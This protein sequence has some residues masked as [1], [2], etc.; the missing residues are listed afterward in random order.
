MIV[1]VE[2]VTLVGRIWW[3][4]SWRARNGRLPACS[5]AGEIWTTRARRSTRPW[6]LFSRYAGGRAGRRVPSGSR[7]IQDVVVGE[8]EFAAATMSSTGVGKRP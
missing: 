7:F 3:V 1:G 8:D 5:I 4:V 6:I 2:Q